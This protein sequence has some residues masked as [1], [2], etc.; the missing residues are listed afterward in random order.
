MCGYDACGYGDT[1][2][3]EMCG[4][5]VDEKGYVIGDHQT[6]VSGY[7]VWG[8]SGGPREWTGTS[9]FSSDSRR[10]VKGGLRGNNERGS[11]CAFAVDES[12]TYA[13]STL[14][15]RCCLDADATTAPPGEAPG[16]GG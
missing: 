7:G 13:D 11:R 4:E 9:A 12:A 14:S 8:M 5:G 1:Y 3:G 16:E 10:V 2:D 15:F 6:C